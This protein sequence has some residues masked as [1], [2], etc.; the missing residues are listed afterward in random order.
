MRSLRRCA[1]AFRSWRDGAAPF[2]QSASSLEDDELFPHGEELAE[3]RHC[4]HAFAPDVSC[5]PAVTHFDIAG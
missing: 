1:P 4:L 2:I 5:V 3:R